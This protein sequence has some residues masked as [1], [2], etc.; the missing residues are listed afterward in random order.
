V[1]SGNFG[2]LTAGLIAKRMGL[3]IEHFVAA[4]NINAIVPE[5]LRTNEFKPRASQSTISNAMDV[6]NPSNVVRMLDLYQNHFEKLKADISGFDFND[7]E[8]QTAMRDVFAN[9]KYVLDPHG[10]IGYLGLKKYSD[11]NPSVTGVFLETAH[12]SKFLDIVENTLNTSIEVPGR[13]K[14][15]I[16][17][18]KQTTRLDTSFQS[19]RQLLQKIL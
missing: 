18:K 6:G 17:N 13:L 12:P 19:F 15:L 14:K 8:T 9:A 5:Y 10:A 11:K 3:P 7:E 16:T 4:T 2:N 1:P